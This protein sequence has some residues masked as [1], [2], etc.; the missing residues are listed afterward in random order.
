MT[1]PGQTEVRDQKGSNDGI[2]FVVMGQT[3]EPVTGPGMVTPRIV[4]PAGTKYLG[5]SLSLSQD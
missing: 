2:P 1:L 4:G 3:D 5:N